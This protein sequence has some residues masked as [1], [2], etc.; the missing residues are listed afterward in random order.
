MINNDQH[1]SIKMTLTMQLTELHYL[2]N[3]PAGNACGLRGRPG[4]GV[5]S[6]ADPWFK[7]SRG[8]SVGVWRSTEPECRLKR[9]AD[10]S[11]NAKRPQ[12]S[13]HLNSTS[14]RQDAGHRGVRGQIAEI[15][16]SDRRRSGRERVRHRIRWKKRDPPT[17]DQSEI[18]SPL[19]E[20]SLWLVPPQTQH[21]M[22]AGT[23]HT[24][25]T[26]SLIT[27][28]FI[29]SA[30]RTEKSQQTFHLSRDFQ[31]FQK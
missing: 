12:S 24:G 26:T 31:R 13:N 15:D 14:G 6:V 17:W 25:L 2:W 19:Q 23:S 16:I 3:R 11:G 22:G 18:R 7:M 9:F 28:E 4:A 8:L 30:L 21:N 10:Q 5:Q 1:S 20:E 27:I 29:L